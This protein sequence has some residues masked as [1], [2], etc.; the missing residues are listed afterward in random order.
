[1]T[2]G[3]E[4]PSYHVI[5]GASIHAHEPRDSYSLAKYAL[6]YLMLLD[7][8]LDSYGVAPDIPCPHVSPEQDGHYSLSKDYSSLSEAREAV[9]L[10]LTYSFPKLL[11]SYLSRER[12]K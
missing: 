8:E 10:R 12:R 4:H 7:C 11:R 6:Q 9:V 3:S 1:M 2:T 5:A